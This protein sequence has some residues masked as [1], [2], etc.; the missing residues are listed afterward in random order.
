LK[1]ITKYCLRLKEIDFDING[2]NEETIREFGEKCGQK[3]EKI[4]FSNREDDRNDDKYK[5]LIKLCPN[6]R[7]LL[8]IK[9]KD[10]VGNNELFLP[11]FKEVFVLDAFE[12]NED[13]ELFEL[14]ANK[15]KDQIKSF[16]HS[17]YKRDHEIVCPL[18]PKYYQ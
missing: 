3:L 7:Q 13:K 11:K 9:L 12:S 8:R 17:A 1:L 18:C 10:I 16:R 5:T 14:F 15:Y 4:R 2:I 6:L